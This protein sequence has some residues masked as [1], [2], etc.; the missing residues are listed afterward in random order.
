MN[1]VP[2]F[3]MAQSPKKRQTPQN[4]KTITTVHDFYEWTVFHGTARFFNASTPFDD[5]AKQLL[6]LSKQNINHIPEKLQ[7]MDKAL[8][9]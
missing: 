5:L 2:M 7:V 1:D 3:T 4:E 9:L 8:V 6:T